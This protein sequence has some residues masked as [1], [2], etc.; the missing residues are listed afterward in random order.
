VA[1]SILLVDDDPETRKA[2]AELL[3]ARGLVVDEARHGREALERLAARRPSVVVTDLVM[4]EMSGWDLVREMK[5]S[6]A[7][8][9]IPVVVL[10]ASAPGE[11][12]ADVRLRKP[13]SFSRI[14][15][16]IRD[17]LARR[18]RGRPSFA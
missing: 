13:C 1:A 9:R 5:Q 10:S 8:T 18:P 16:A 11:I 14:L 6:A 4:P 3:R 15:T 7:L 2:L 17:L 12:G